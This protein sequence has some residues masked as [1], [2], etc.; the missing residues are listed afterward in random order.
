MSAFK[1]VGD[2]KLVEQTLFRA[3]GQKF[4]TLTLPNLQGAA[5]TPIGTGL[6]LTVEVAHV[7]TGKYPRTILGSSPM[8]ITSAIKNLSDVGAGAEAVNYLVNKVGKNTNF[9]SPPADTE[10]TRLVCYVP[11]VTASSTTVTLNLVFEI[12]PDAAFQEIGSIFSGLGALPIFLTQSPYLLGAQ[13][14][15]K[16]VQDI[17]DAIFNGKPNYSPTFTINF[18]D[19]GDATQAG[20]QTYFN[21]KDDSTIDG[22]TM[23]FVPNKG[24]IDPRTNKAYDGDAPYFVIAIDGAQRDDLKGFAPLAATADMLS[25]FFNIKDGG[26]I[27]VSDIIGVFSSANDVSYGEKALAIKAKIA[28]APAGTDT[29]ALQAQLK[30]YLANIQ[31]DSLSK[32]FANG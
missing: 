3:S 7:Y 25:T 2:G 31:S 10:G 22:S 23:T 9:P 1:V 18:A 17:G 21:A 14:V 20:Y 8:L 29:T 16:V 4:P 15:L 24:L 6:P 19:I 32:L 30:A 5:F 13:S 27:P 12:F 28:A 26:L 11:A